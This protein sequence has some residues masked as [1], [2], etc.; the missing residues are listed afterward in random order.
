MSRFWLAEPPARPGRAITAVNVHDGQGAQAVTQTAEAET[1]P[2][3]MRAASSS[4]AFARERRPQHHLGAARS[5]TR[6]VVRH[7]IRLFTGADQDHQPRGEPP[8]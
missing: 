5:A 7:K 6:A 4:A 2:V 1:A 3:I 8:T